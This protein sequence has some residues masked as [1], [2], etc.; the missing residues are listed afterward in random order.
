M[1]GKYK[2]ALLLLADAGSEGLN[3]EYL[4]ESI[5]TFGLPFDDTEL[6]D[7]IIEFHQRVLCRYW[8]GENL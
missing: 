1:C 5:K 6:S 7:F 8:K 4:K 3:A 2:L